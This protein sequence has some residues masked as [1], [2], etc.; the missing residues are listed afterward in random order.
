MNHLVQHIHKTDLN[1]DN[2]LHVIGVIENPMRYQS[3]IRLFREW[4]AAMLKTPNVKVYVVETAYGDRRFEVTEKDNP[5][6]LQL[7]SHQPIWHKENMIN[8]G[9]KH[10]LPLDWKYVSWCD[11]DVFF[12]HEGWALESLHQMQDYSLIQ[13]WSD[14]LDLGFTGRV[15]QTFKSLC[16]QH[17]LGVP[18]QMHPSQPYQYAHSGFA[19]CARR[20][21]WEAVGGLM[22]FAILGSAD[23]HMAFASIGEVMNT[24]HKGMNKNFFTLC[25][26]WQDKAFRHTNGQLGYVPGFLK[27][28]FHG[29]KARRKYRERWEILVH[30]HYDPIGNLVHDTQGLTKVIGNHKLINDCRKYMLHRQ[31]DSIEDY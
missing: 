15:L 27:H 8:L 29:P 11:A 26:Q 1:S 31:E 19:W 4:Y 20:D 6:H 21:F 9:V 5:Q 10:L 14:C 18:K 23:H 25:G 16:Y 22:D 24:I 12:D 17:Q 3:R 30:D 28:K 7:H 2:T 13:P